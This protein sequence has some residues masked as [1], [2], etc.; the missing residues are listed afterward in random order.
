MEI[1]R[2]AQ[3]VAVR[4]EEAVGRG[5][6]PAAFREVEEGVRFKTEVEVLEGR[7]GLIWDT[8]EE[9]AMELIPGYWAE[10]GRSLDGEGGT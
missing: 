3:G 4:V 6:I 10:E 9:V 1:A 8:I 2:S 7:I 5:D